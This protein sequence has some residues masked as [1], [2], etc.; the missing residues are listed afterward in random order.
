MQIGPT[1]EEVRRQN[2][3]AL[4]RYVHLHGATSRAELTARLG[5]NRSTIGAL[6]ADLAGA[7]LVVEE[8]PRGLGRAGR[9][10]LVVRPEPGVYVFALVVE[11]DRLVAA[12]IGLG[13]TILDRRQ[14]RRPPC[15]HA[16]ATV[17]APLVDLVRDMQRAIPSRA[18][19]VGSGAAVSA[20]VRGDDGL[21][22]LVENVD[23]ID[24]PLGAALGPVLGAEPAV[25]VR[26]SADLSALAEHVRG[27]AVGCDNV[28]YVTGD[29]GIGGGII[30]GGHLVT[31]RGGH[32]GEV[33]HMV[34]NPAGRPCGC[35]SH[36]CWE[37]EIGEHALLRAA[38]RDLDGKPN[39][40]DTV[41]AVVEA[42]AHGDQTAQAAI[43]Q[44]ADWL[45]FGVANLVNIFNP[46]MVIFGGTLCE[47]YIAGAAQVRSRLNR[48]ALAAHR[49]HVRLRT[50]TLGEDVAL[51][52]AAELAFTPL[53]R[54]PLADVMDSVA[55]NAAE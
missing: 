34:V 15:A 24:E 44:I 22:R 43:R 55:E 33:G 2:L 14:A 26:N 6:T 39:G 9:P 41:R 52:G 23:W 25:A 53:L 40:R 12:R 50:P 38:R 16:P 45:G 48:N 7:G 32:G 13:G 19:Y 18:R 51:L 3:G 47:L 10:S 36:G 30:A 37:T 28:V 5:L 11:V 54:N 46:D 1:Q 29:A 35:G 4:L 8:L 27:A 17:V 20:M 42:A 49:A 31:G 21:V